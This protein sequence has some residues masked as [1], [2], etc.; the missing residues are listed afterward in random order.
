ME[1]CQWRG[2]EWCPPHC[3]IENAS[4]Q[5]VRATWNQPEVLS[6]STTDKMTNMMAV[7]LVMVRGL[8]LRLMAAMAGTGATE[9]TG[10][11]WR[12]M[13]DGHARC[14]H[15]VSGLVSPTLMKITTWRTV[16]LE[17]HRDLHCQQCSALP[18]GYPDLTQW[19]TL[20]LKTVLPVGEETTKQRIKVSLRMSKGVSMVDGWKKQSTGRYPRKSEKLAGYLQRLAW[21]S[22]QEQLNS[23]ESFYLKFTIWAS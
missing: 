7:P 21:F 9:P 12:P 1:P 2:H 4:G 13:G 11:L 16:V 3:K 10:P 14:G 6:G 15:P 20:M 23:S 18:D 5:V 17:R 19:R 22:N 8:T